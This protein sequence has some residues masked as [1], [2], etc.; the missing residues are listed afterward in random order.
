MIIRVTN[1]ILYDIADLADNIEENFGPQYADVFEQEIRDTLVRLG[2]NQ[3]IYPGTGIFY[4]G[5]EI[6]KVVMRPSLI[7][8]VVL[9]NEVHVL[10]A[11]RQ[12]RNW[13][14]ILRTETDY[15]YES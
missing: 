11:L 6:R 4:R 5:S 3:N 13:D 1:E 10:R 8:Y 9:E 12:E 7:F 14:K 15:S 2:S